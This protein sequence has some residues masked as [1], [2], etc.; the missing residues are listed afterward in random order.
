MNGDVVLTRLT[1]VIIS[2]HTHISSHYVIHQK[3]IQSHMSIISPQNNKPI[4]R[5]NVKTK[6]Q[7]ILPPHRSKVESHEH[8]H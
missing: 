1:A 4:R 7:Q 6:K 2:Q 8:N 3:L 5:H